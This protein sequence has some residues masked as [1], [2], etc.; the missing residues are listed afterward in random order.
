MPHPLFKY[1][2]LFINR[3]QKIIHSFPNG[4]TIYLFLAIFMPALPLYASETCLTNKVL[5]IPPEYQRVADATG[6]SVFR[7]EKGE[8]NQLPPSLLIDV[9]HREHFLK[10]IKKFAPDEV[11]TLPLDS[12]VKQLR[13]H[14]SAQQP[15]AFELHTP[16]DKVVTNKS[17]SDTSVQHY[18]SGCVVLVE[19]PKP[20]I[21]T[22][23]IRSSGKVSVDARGKT[24]VSF[25]NFNYVR[26]GDRQGHQS[27]KRPEAGAYLASVAVIN[28]NKNIQNI[29]EFQIRSIDGAIIG[30]IV[31]K[32]EDKNS[33]FGSYHLDPSRVPENEQR[34]YVVGV[35]NKGFHFQRMYSHSIKGLPSTKKNIDAEDE[36]GVTALFNAIYAN[37]MNKTQSLI[38]A[39][40]NVNH[41]LK[42]GGTTLM[43][44]IN[45]HDCSILQLLLDQGADV[46]AID[47]YSA[48]AVFKATV[49]KNTQAVK[50]LLELG[51]DPTI[52][53]G[54]GY[55]AYQWAKK[56]DFRAILTLLQ[57]YLADMPVETS[58]PVI[59]MQ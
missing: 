52:R 33:L 31:S 36:Y 6:G 38:T 14:I 43:Y 25:V 35:D 10:L 29:E 44:A 40:A 50:M 18:S 9:T 47:K 22:M 42:S 26:L 39:G 13:V 1:F 12:S 37:N 28:S 8:I 17:F 30:R 2:W 23:H 49:A 53:D 7:L 48:T 5:S 3:C 41:R 58:A 4:L 56:K 11:V 34:I 55:T 45:H 19:N 15:M 54:S 57:P 24:L 32:P 27:V 51:A 16:N 21:W 46:N 59:D 20:G